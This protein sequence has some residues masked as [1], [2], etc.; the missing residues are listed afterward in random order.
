[1]DLDALALSAF[2]D[3][4]RLIRRTMDSAAP[5]VLLDAPT[6]YGKTVL[7]T[8]W[9]A[10]DRRPFAWVT[11]ADEHNDP[12]ALLAAILDAI[13]E[14]D[15]LP[16][17]IRA[18]LASPEPDLEG[19]VLPR[20]ERGL[21]GRRAPLVLVLDELEHIF[22]PQ[23]VRVIRALVERVPAG[24]QVA[25]S[26]RAAP[27]L[28][29]GR[30][31]ANRRLTELRRSDLTM[32][33]GE[34]EGLLAGVASFGLARAD[35][36]TLVRRTEGWPAALYLAAVAL[37]DEPDRG[38]AIARFAGD[39]RIVVDYIREE[40]LA[41]AS[42]RRVE[43][44]RRVS[45]LDRLSGGLCDAVLER[46]GSAA[47]LRNLSRENVL[48]VPLD[49]RDEW[50]RFHSLLAEMLRAD[51]R[52]TEPEKEAE[53]HGRAS[54]WWAERG[55]AGRAIHHAIAG[56]DAARAGELL[57]AAVPEY[58]AQGRSAT[59]QRWV[60]QLGH[61][62]L[63]VDPFV[64]LTVAH[65]HLSRGE[66]ALAQHWADVTRRLLTAEG[67]AK[68]RRALAPGLALLDGT[69]ARDG[70][71]RMREH[72]AVAADAA[73]DASPWTSMC[74][75]IDGIGLAL[76]D[77]REDAAERLAESARR[78]AVANAA[79]IQ[80]IALAELALIAADQGDWQ[81]ARTLASQGRAQVERS[82]LEAL[83]TMAPVLAASAFVRANTGTKVDAAADLRAGIRLLGG[84]DEFGAWFEVQTQIVLGRAAQALGDAARA[85]EL[86]AV[87]A[88]RL[89]TLEGA[90]LLERWQRDAATA[91][92]E[93]S[94]ATAADLTPAEVRVL[95]LLPTHL[96]FPQIASEMY[97]SP[98]TVKSQAQA[99]YRKLGVTS[100]RE[101]VE[102][103]AAAGIITIG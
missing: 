39:D 63:G 64:T 48:L 60:E 71:G 34:C 54:T 92:K 94:A 72:A 80:C 61:E 76:A 57:W 16:E 52:R 36:D 67:P 100:R 19:T 27:P 6:G 68:R 49:R 79:I 101:A 42:N 24:S 59:L 98:N 21:S 102:H 53:L 33:R 85:R 50:F 15:P 13:E 89:E 70:V 93:A 28:P 99:V 5:V 97:V 58:M 11:L 96:T 103:A 22:S 83:P 91:A 3:R 8:Q 37:L 30:M 1:M 18:A 20:L 26:T 32:T 23:S 31:R 29:L 74:C 10:V 43:F 55:D 17:E 25:L 41:T 51:L 78:A 81:R 46:S 87:S 88:D 38:G 75:L 12:A 82:G 73:P 35:V 90:P 45:I 7:L 9:A 69:L 65:G 62:R 56:G 2:V 66:G 84:L 77:R 44:L 86:L 47:T 95:D 40:F 14:I 4:P